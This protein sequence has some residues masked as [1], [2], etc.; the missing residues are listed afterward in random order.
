MKGLVQLFLLEDDMTT[1]E[2]VRN[3]F[4]VWL[5]SNYNYTNMVEAL[6]HDISKQITGYYHGS[7]YF[8]TKYIDNP[9]YDGDCSEAQEEHCALFWSMLPTTELETM[10]SLKAFENVYKNFVEYLKSNN[11]PEVSKQDFLKELLENDNFERI[12]DEVLP[13]YGY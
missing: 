2:L 7:D 9:P 5:H 8:D 6:V 13:G 3:W 4:D 1:K 10:L 12:A 11:Q